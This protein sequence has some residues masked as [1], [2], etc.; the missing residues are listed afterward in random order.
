M[1]RYLLL[2]HADEDAWEELAPELREPSY[3]R[4]ASL[5]REMQER[6]HARGG[7]ELTASTTAKVVRVRDGERSVVD[8]PFI[9]T[10]EQLGGYFAVEC[11]LET[12]LDYAARIP[13]A[14][15]GAVEVREVAEGPS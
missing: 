7:D 9:E 8:G 3:E 14:E 12:A 1:T 10:K 2:I 4:Y 5:A 6:G 15:H 13:G 11:D